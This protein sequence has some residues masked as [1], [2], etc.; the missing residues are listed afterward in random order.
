MILKIQNTFEQSND[1]VSMCVLFSNIIDG[2]SI[3]IMFQIMVLKVCMLM[4]KCKI[5]TYLTCVLIHNVP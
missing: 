2:L 1:Y 4:M 3:K 5:I